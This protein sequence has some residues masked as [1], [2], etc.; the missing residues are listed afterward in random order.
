MPGSWQPLGL[1]QW[2]ALRQWVGLCVS[3]AVALLLQPTAWAAVT[4]SEIN[5]A[6]QIADAGT[7]GMLRRVNELVHR[8]EPGD[9]PCVIVDTILLFGEVRYA[10]GTSEG[11]LSAVEAALT[12]ARIACDEARVADLDALAGQIQLLQRKPSVA[13]A[14]ERIENALQAQRRT[15][16]RKR[17]IGQI[18]AYSTILA[19]LRQ[20]AAAMRLSNEAMTL[21]GDSGGPMTFLTFSVLSSRVELLRT[22][23]DNQSALAA[24]ETLLD[25]VAAS[26]NA[27]FIGYAQL[28]VAKTSRKLGLNSRAAQL[29]EAAYQH[30]VDDDN[31]LAQMIAALDRA[32]VALDNGDV[33]LSRQWLDRVQP[34]KPVLDESDLRALFDL[35]DAHV[36][37]RERRPVAA[38]LALERAREG[39]SPDDARDVATLRETEAEVLSS[40]NRLAEAIPVWRDAL[41]LRIQAARE[42]QAV[43]VAAQADLYR[44]SEREVREKQLEAEVQSH[45]SQLETVERRLVSQRLIAAGVTLA[46]VL[47]VWVAVWQ[48]RRAR[49]FRQYAEFDALTGV[50]SRSAM[51]RIGASRMRR[52]LRQKEP[53]FVL[54]F[55]VDGLK[56]INDRDGHARGDEL[57]QHV[58]RLISVGLRPRDRLGRWGGDE[59]VAVFDNMEPTLVAKNASRLCAVVADGLLAAGFAEASCSVG[60]TAVAAADRN[61]AQVLARADAALYAAKHGGKN[62][63]R[64]AHPALPGEPRDVPLISVPEA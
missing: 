26:G 44:I 63:A 51:E 39:L 59:F 6:N 7:M 64:V 42:M 37:A 41:A 61:F 36:A 38:R 3:S 48:L 22:I 43:V 2:L 11:T 52:W 8:L 19:E 58:A 53:Y 47:A 54:L 29:F 31:P 18:D 56:L 60:V 49:R 1:R 32:S 27:M 55:D 4:A 34:L 12:L 45:G 9:A 40:E 35:A 5:A 20:Y 50:L 10:N 15:G 30:A 24:A 13:A 16:D 33:A 62:Q 14:R 25:R 21:L 28:D 17:L 46:A 57:L 23:G